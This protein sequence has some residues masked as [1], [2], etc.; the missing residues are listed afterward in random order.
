MLHI[1]NGESAG[2]GHLQG[3]DASWRW[4]RRNKTLVES[5]VT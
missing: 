5:I 4:D 2:G 3:Q 1:T